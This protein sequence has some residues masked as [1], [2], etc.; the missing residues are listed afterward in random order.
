MFAPRLLLGLA[1]LALFASA[2]PAAPLVQAGL[3]TATVPCSS[4]VGGIDTLDPLAGP[5]CADLIVDPVIMRRTTTLETRTFNANS[6]DVAEGHVTPGTHRLLRWTYNTPNIG[7]SDLVVGAPGAHPEW[8]EWAPCHRHY[9]FREYADY[10]LWTV[11]GFESY[12]ATRLANPGKTFLQLQQ[13][14]PSIDD[15][16]ITGH[17]NGFCV[18]DLT[19]ALG[20]PGFL[21]NYFSC[22][23]QGISVGMADEYHTSLSGQWIVVDGV[24]SGDY[25]L[26]NEVNA[27]RMFHELNYDNNWWAVPVKL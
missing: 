16:L 20:A 11:A 3:A 15:G 6:C 24:P 10:R 2:L 9:H 8:F 23:N 14:F 13:E 26:E 19:T 25:I 4:V 18:I 17:K 12:A 7:T 5:L 21:G 1:A 27:E 22:G